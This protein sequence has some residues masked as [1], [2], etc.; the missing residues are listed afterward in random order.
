MQKTISK[1]VQSEFEGLTKTA[2][3][4]VISIQ[5]ASLQIGFA[6]SYSS[7]DG[8]ILQPVDQA[9]KGFTARINGADVPDNANL[10]VDDKAKLVA[11]QVIYNNIIEALRP[12]ISDFIDITTAPL[13]A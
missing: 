8:T 12:V 10:S 5:G 11:D 13:Q 4:A 6:L 7:P 1:Q 9:K 3:L 2:T